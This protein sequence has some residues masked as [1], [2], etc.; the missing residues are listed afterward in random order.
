MI[1]PSVI[2]HHPQMPYLSVSSASS[3]LGP[4]LCLA[5]S[6]F[7][8]LQW[9][10]GAIYNSLTNASQSAL[11][12]H[13]VSA[14]PRR[15]P[16]RLNPTPDATRWPECIRHGTK[17]QRVLLPKFTAR[18]LHFFASVLP[19]PLFFAHKFMELQAKRTGLMTFPFPSFFPSSCKVLYT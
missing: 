12:A 9:L 4:S 6:W 14:P 11:T 18:V 8:R 19:D 3:T 13:I 5:L 10:F 17:A 2:A 16:S 15:S 1:L 7:N